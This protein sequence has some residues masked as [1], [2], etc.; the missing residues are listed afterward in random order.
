MKWQY[1]SRVKGTNVS[2]DALP[3][4]LCMGEPWPVRDARL[5]KV[6]THLPSLINLPSYFV[7]CNHC[8]CLRRWKAWIPL[9]DIKWERA[10][11]LIFKSMLSRNW[12]TWSCNPSNYTNFTVWA[13]SRSGFCGKL[14]SKVGDAT[15]KF[16]PVSSSESDGFF[17]S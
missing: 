2:M 12:E 5:L 7:S 11:N 1:I 17:F 10:L 13:Y 15:L 6:E 14:S 3:R 16:P 8:S 9:K 4:S